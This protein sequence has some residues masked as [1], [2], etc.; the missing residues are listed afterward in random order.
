MPKVIALVRGID[1][2]FCGIWVV[3]T[4]RGLAS[5][6]HIVYFEKIR[7]FKA[8]EKASEYISMG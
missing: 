6:F 1:L 8:G 4:L 3:G 2:L 7:V 5:S